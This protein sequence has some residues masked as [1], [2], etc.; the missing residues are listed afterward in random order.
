MYSAV[1]KKK[2]FS[3]EEFKGVDFSSSPIEIDKRRSPNAKNII[4]NNGY[5]ESRNGYKILNTIGN[6]VN[7]I[8]NID[9][10]K[11][12]LFLAHSGDSLYECSNDFSEFVCLLSGMNNARST[13]I[14][15][16]EYLV[17]FDGNRTVLYSDFGN[18]Y[19]AKFLDECG[20]VPTTSIA[21]DS[22]GGGT[23]YEKVNLI[24]PYQINTFLPEKIQKE[25]ISETGE[26]VYESIDQTSFIL[27]E[28]E[29][30][31]ISLVQVLKDTG[32]W[33]VIPSSDYT[34]D[35]NNT[36]TFKSAPGESPVLGRDSV[37]IKFKKENFENKDK[38][39]KCNIATLYGYDGNNNRIFVT[40][41]PD[42]PNYD[43]HCEQD[44]P[45]YF[46]D[47]NFTKVGVEPITNYLRL[48]DGTLAIQKKQ[49]D[50]DCTV[51]YRTSNLLD[52]VEVF[53]LTDGVKNIG[54]ISKYANANLLNDPLTLTNQGIFAIIGSNAGEKYAQQRSYY[55]NKKLMK[56]E[57]LEE[58]VA[59]TVA[60]KYYLAVNN[61]MYIA[62]SRYLSYP[63]HAKTEQYQYEWYYWDNIPARVL[64]N[65]N[66]QL[67]F[68]T[69]D[70]KVCIFSDDYLDIDK[71][72]EVYWETPF[73][74]LNSSSLAKTIKQVTLILNP[75]GDCDV[76][77]GYILDDGSEEIIVK[78]YSALTD[79][80]PK[81]IQEKA[82]IRKFMFIKFF[83]KNNTK[84]RMT[85]ERLILEYINSGKYRGE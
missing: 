29:I 68:G 27:G 19:E 24:C 38:I 36:V 35:G 57:N 1:T 71:P 10:K 13:G 58:A 44:D 80:F 59:I 37:S 26:V 12:E 14:Y 45:T 82:K 40:G 46:P 15:F 2:T 28:T 34:F 65:W 43:F 18:G 62:D 4:N 64:C 85:F 22:T 75:G 84:N 74:E 48:A 81:T 78:G 8:W 51:Y 67:I 25:T 77:F 41:N 30:D 11:G 55:V 32:V 66:D 20:R 31:E 39:N 54:C 50:T 23:D 70:G 33:E 52:T 76:T 17:I 3:I 47:E 6:C 63:K 79:D 83:I 9:T 56:E 73:L 42:F 60:G 5:N 7:G 53:P 49:T 72:V 61:H 21:R 16:N 69:S